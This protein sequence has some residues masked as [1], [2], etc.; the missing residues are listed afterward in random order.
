LRHFLRYAMTHSMYSFPPGGNR[1]RG[2]RASCRAAAAGLSFLYIA[3]SPFAAAAAELGSAQ[4]FTF[5]W[6]N[7]LQ[8]SAGMRL[9]G[10]GKLTRSYPNVDDGDRNFAAGLMTDRFDLTS[11]LDATGET[12]GAELTLSAWYDFAYQAGTHNSS[13][14][15]YNALSA[16]A[17]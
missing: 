13:P 10:I 15:T 3:L 11:V 17:G 9:T 8:Y 7:S 12:M 2:L 16:P 5:R 1:W 14:G 6:D 4:G